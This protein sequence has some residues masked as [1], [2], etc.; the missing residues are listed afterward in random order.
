MPTAVLVD[1]AFFI[2]RFR[3]I[4]PQNAFNAERA[5]DLVH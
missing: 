4:E 3:R 1:G 2:K 5:A